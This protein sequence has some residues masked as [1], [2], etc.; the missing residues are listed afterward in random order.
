MG[1][2]E[3]IT[4]EELEFMETLCDSTAMAETLWNDYDN[5]Q[6]YSEDKFGHIRLGQLSMLSHEYMIDDQ[7]PSLTKKENFKRL[8]G[9]GTLYNFGARRF[10]KCEWIENECLLLD[11]SLVKYKDLIGQTV[12]VL[13]LNENTNKIVPA[14]AEIYDNGI[15]SCYEITTKS[16]K[17][18]TLTEN[19]PLLTEFGWTNVNKLQ[20]GEFLACPRS[21][22]KVLTNTDKVS[23]YEAILLGYLIGDGSCTGQL[24]I[25]NINKEIVD[26][27]YD[28]ADYYDCE[29]RKCKD[30]PTYFFKAKD[31][32]YK[33]NKKTNNPLRQRSNLD[34][35][36]DKY[37]IRKKA[38]YKTI[39]IQVFNW[40]NKYI[41]LLLN[42]YF[43]CDGHVNYS[44]YS[45]ELSSSSKKLLQ[46]VQ[47]LLLRF[48][49]Q[50][51]HGFNENNTYKTKTGDMKICPA[52]RLYIAADFDK[53]MDKIGVF[54]KDKGIRKNK[55]YS[56][57]DRIPNHFLQTILYP[58]AKGFRKK[59]GIKPSVKDNCS[60][61]KW[62]RFAKELKNKEVDK[63][64]FSDIFW[65]EIKNIEF[66]G[67]LPTAVVSVEK[68]HN[69][70][71]NDIISHNSLISL[72]IDMLES[73]IHLDNWHCLYSSYDALHILQIL[74]RVIPAAENHPF[75]QLFTVKTKR[76]PN[77]VITSRNG[78]EIQSVNMN[79]SSKT[80][81]SNFFGHHTK[82]LWIDE[83][84]KT[85]H[86]VEEKVIDAT[87]ELGCIERFSGM[88]DFTRHSPAGRIYDD[89]KRKKWVCNFPQYIS[90][91]WD[92]GERYKQERRYGGTKTVAY[93]TFVKGEVCEDGI[94]VFDM[95]RVR[96]N[97]NEK[98]KIKNFEI[99]KDNFK[100]FKQILVVERPK[101]AE[102]CIMGA[103]IGETAPSELVIT[104]K[105]NE[106]YNYT[107][108]VTLYNLTDKQQYRIFKYLIIL[109][110]IE[111][112][113]L[114]CG[115]GT[116]RSIYRRLE[117][118]FTNERLFFYDGSKKIA[119]GYKKDDD[120]RVAMINGK[121]EV[122]EEFMAEWSVKHFKTILYDTLMVIPQDFKFDTQ[123]NSVISLTLSNR[124]VY[125][126]VSPQN[127]LFDAFKVWALTQWS[128]SFNESNFI[129]RKAFSKTGV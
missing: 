29:V 37:D 94:S 68:H 124:T 60:R 11:G 19:H 55:P 85:T 102:L 62:Q 63:I 51:F 120:G 18:I 22:E 105:I 128:I 8:E 115:D 73:M 71:S 95:E 86:E 2:V 35:A 121:P 107:Y 14:K 56:T 81:G 40:D 74:E 100:S 33:W 61:L 89:Y 88:T 118:D 82:K 15:K 31:L 49:I 28:I 80:A 84:S 21:Y 46:Q 129:K 70:I 41:A 4:E 54:S 67:D 75:F 45:I 113:G 6:I 20:I 79:I 64:A 77:Y 16:G 101:N 122:D 24:G 66:V 3:R 27:I 43:A 83:Y 111:A 65:D 112:T 96:A 1:L 53:F 44:N 39:P 38:I 9:A 106:K 59:L 109:L 103:D 72:I 58:N 17:K 23:E 97:Y 32:K 127:H 47:H 91:M 48:G 116:G 52:G 78:F 7:D 125:E 13:A 25:T 119:V 30:E 90:P 12:D 104:F 42:R 92:E 114:D 76:S 10:G 26:E 93:R 87:A 126:C 110:N 98:K 36:I 34:L 117:E 5:L 69:Y 50:S 57:G 99:N 108:N 123:I